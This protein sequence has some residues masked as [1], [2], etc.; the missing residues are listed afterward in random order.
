MDQTN[1]VLLENESLNKFVDFADKGRLLDQDAQLSNNGQKMLD[2]ATVSKN[3][4]RLTNIGRLDDQRAL[5]PEDSIAEVVFKT[6]RGKMEDQ[7]LKLTKSQKLGIEIARFEDLI[8]EISER[9]D[10]Q[11]APEKDT[12]DVICT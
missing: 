6:M 9:M 2:L 3:V 1:N 4:E 11:R 10:D 7:E 8:N 5:L 12:K